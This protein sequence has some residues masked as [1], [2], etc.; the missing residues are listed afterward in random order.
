M[1]GLA[2]D[3][4]FAG[5][6]PF[7]PI[8]FDT[9][10]GKIHYID[11]GPIDAVPVVMVHG[12]PTWG[13]L[14]R[15][16]IKAVVAQGYRAI[17]MDH[18]GFGRSDKPDDT[19]HYAIPRHADRCEALL[20]S[21]NLQN[22]VVVV[23]DWGGPIGLTWAARH[24]DRVAGLF[25]LNTFFQ[26]PLSKVPLPLI[27]KAFRTPGIGE[28][29]VKGAH[30]F[31]R[32][33]LFQGGLHNPSRLTANDKAAYLAPHPTWSSRTG[34]LAFPRQ[35][36]SGSDG[37]ISDFVDHEGGKLRAAFANK[38]V[39]IVWPMNDLAFKPETLERMW[40]RDFPH[41]EAKRV[42]NAGHYIQED[43]PEIVI[44][45]LLA[46]IGTVTGNPKAVS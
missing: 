32:G 12:N 3:W 36:P 40:M 9:P 30:A 24:S 7:A 6:W 16:F 27:L 2:Q 43:T 15:N 11:E 46:F 8:W 29:L 25:I 34:I 33:F 41:A 19:S 23:Q 1:T 21:L 10:D 31:V 38:P 45:E 17:V 5:K 44:P 26:R 4:T 20:E 39:K 13:Y 14:Y 42:E 22:A 37:P 28:L 35:I 18:L